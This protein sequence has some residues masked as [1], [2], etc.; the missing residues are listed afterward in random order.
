VM[1]CAQRIDASFAQR[2]CRIAYF[3]LNRNIFFN[4]RHLFPD[5]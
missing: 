2:T 5:L 4:E 3:H 1:P